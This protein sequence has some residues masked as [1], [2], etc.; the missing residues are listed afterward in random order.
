MQTEFSER[1]A[2]TDLLTVQLNQYSK[3]GLKKIGLYENRPTGL[4]LLHSIDRIKNHCQF[5][6]IC[7][8]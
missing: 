6:I 1:F 7:I 3:T 5:V 4:I 8:E 2:Y